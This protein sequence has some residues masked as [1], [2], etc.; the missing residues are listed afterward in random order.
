MANGAAGVR[1]V[2]PAGPRGPRAG[3]AA[4]RP[5]AVDDAVAPP[6][7]VVAVVA[8]AG[9]GAGGRPDREAA[10]LLLVAD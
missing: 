8:V 9:A 5:A 2:A 7:G 6:D 1:R 10:D 3:R 4:A